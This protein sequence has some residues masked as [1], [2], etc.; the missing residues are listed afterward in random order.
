MYLVSVLKKFNTSPRSFIEKC[1]AFFCNC[2]KYNEISH[3]LPEMVSLTTIK[4]SLKSQQIKLED[5][6]ACL[7]VDC[8]MCG[9][10]DPQTKTKVPRLYINKTTGG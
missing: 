7:I 2:R 5:G 1:D 6:H 9:P 3:G 4:R 8:P 10:H